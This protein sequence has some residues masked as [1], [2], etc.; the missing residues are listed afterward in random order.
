MPI[1]KIKNCNKKYYGRGYCQGHYNNLYFYPSHKKHIRQYQNEYRRKHYPPTKHL[2]FIPKCNNLVLVKYKYCCLHRKRMAG[3]IKDLDLS[4]NLKN[5]VGRFTKGKLNVNWKGGIAEYPN[6]YLMKKNRLIIL[7]QNPKCEI[8]G[9]PAIQIHHKDFSK[10]NHQLSNLMA[11]CIKCN[12][13]LRNPKKPNTSKYRRL[14]R[15]TLPELSK[16]YKLSPSQ[17]WRRIQRKIPLNLPKYQI[18]RWRYQTEL[19]NYLIRN[20]NGKEICL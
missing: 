1:C 5:L 12:C 8:C 3:K 7:M 15:G 2:C 19:D 13:N 17:I 20:K 10:S 14:F 18:Y 11:V 4:K 16:K 6:H 9:K